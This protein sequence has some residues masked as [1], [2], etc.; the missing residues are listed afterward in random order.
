[1][2]IHL[3]KIL[4]HAHGLPCNEG[5]NFTNNPG[6]TSADEVSSV[7]STPGCEL[8]L[9][10]FIAGKLWLQLQD[11]RKNLPPQTQWDDSNPPASDASHARIRSDYYRTASVILRPSLFHAVHHV[12]M[13]DIPEGLLREVLQEHVT[14]LPE[15]LFSARWDNHGNQL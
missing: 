10:D 4:S 1:M 12:K 8:A 13:Q 6:A 7:S 14:D 2:Q 3:Q 15:E 5:K 9:E 11:W